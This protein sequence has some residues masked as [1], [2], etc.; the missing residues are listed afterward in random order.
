MEPSLLPPIVSSLP[1]GA[2][3]VDARTGR[4]YHRSAIWSEAARRSRSMAA[5]GHRPGQPA[6]V[7]EPDGTAALLDIFAIWTAG[8]IAVVA[9]PTLTEG[10]KARAC[11]AT[12][13]RFWLGPNPPSDAIGVETSRG[14]E[15]E[16]GPDLSPR[17]RLSPDDSALILMTSGTTSVPKG[18]VHSLRSL[19]SRIAL[20]LCFMPA[21]DLVRTLNVLPVHF[22]HGLIGNCLTPLMAGS[23]LFVWSG[24]EISEYRELGALIDEERITFMSSVPSFWRVAM[25]ASSE[26]AQALRRVHVGSA[27][28]SVEEWQAISDWTKTRRV[29]NMYGMT[30]TAN[31]IAGC[32]LEGGHLVD[33]LVGRAWGGALALLRDGALASDGEGEVVVHSPSIMQGYHGQPGLTAAAFHGSWFR[34]GDVGRVEKDGELIL[35][36]RIKDEINRAGIKIAPAEVD[37]LLG[38]HPDVV[39]ACAFAMPD[40]VA[41]EIVAAAVVLGEGS[42]ADMEAIRAWCR[43]RIRAEAVPSRL[44]VMQAIPRTERGKTS[45]DM[46]RRAA[47]AEE[48]AR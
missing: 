29:L 22:G 39:D 3:I 45:R 19:F 7:A 2:E 43:E 37:L 48:P 15:L 47:L 14:H 18:V 5:A 9:P 8:G 17:P 40:Q 16:S 24:I 26:P 35:V 13:A 31:W 25:R 21:H 41:G 4:S 32:S 1:E 33:G 44:F 20:N 38:R 12:G 46:V 11:E 42:T 23:R 6:V 10:E 36:G 28:L 27:P 34:T 30:E